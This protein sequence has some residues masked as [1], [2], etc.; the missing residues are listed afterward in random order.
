MII[1][2][3]MQGAGGVEFAT[4]RLK[5]GVTEADLLALAHRVES[6]FL[7]QQSELIVHCLLRGA[8]GIYADLVM[9]PSQS[10]VEAYCQQWLHNA[11]A[12]EY[13]TLLDPD[14]VNMSFWTRIG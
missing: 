7:V 2:G 8:D 13:L 1:K 10:L 4:F 6:E 5:E 3:D 11:V 9:A 14:S 12:G